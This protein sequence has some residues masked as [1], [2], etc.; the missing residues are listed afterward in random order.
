MEI[1]TYPDLEQSS[2]LGIL[3][4]ALPFQLLGNSGGFAVLLLK[5]VLP[6]PAPSREAAASSLCG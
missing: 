5:R 3:E 4:F 2:L 6:V 1:P